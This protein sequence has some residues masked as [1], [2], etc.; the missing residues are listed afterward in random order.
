[1]ASFLLNVENHDDIL[2]VGSHDM[3]DVRW[4]IAALP[5]ADNRVALAVKYIPAQGGV[6]T[7]LVRNRYNGSTACPPAQ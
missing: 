6:G 1:M 5:D 3:H 7:I 2:E 4:V